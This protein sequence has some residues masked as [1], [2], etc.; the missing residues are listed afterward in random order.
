MGDVLAAD[1]R[2]LWPGAEAPGGDSS[3]PAEGG[4]SETFFNA[5]L[6]SEIPENFDSKSP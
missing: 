6:K 3:S 5:L 1:T 2:T 4:A